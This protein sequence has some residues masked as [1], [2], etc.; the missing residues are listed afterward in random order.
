MSSNTKSFRCTVTEALTRLEGAA[1]RLELG[2][3][4]LK[5]EEDHIMSGI[6]NL[7]AGVARLKTVGES[8][9]QLLQ[10][11]SAMLAQSSDPAMQALADEVNADLDGIQA[12]IVANTPA[13]T[14]PTPPTEAPAS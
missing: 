8:N 4:A 14:E 1:A 12:D 6:S 5:H 9:R 7:R 11:L 13:A 3:Q 2:L 10:N